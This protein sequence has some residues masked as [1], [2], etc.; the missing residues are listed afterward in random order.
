MLPGL[1]IAINAAS[2]SSA[3]VISVTYTL[4]DPDGL[5]LDA[6]GA[7]TP[8]IISLAYVAAYIPQGQQQYFAYTTEQATGAALGTITRPFFEL[9]GKATQVGPGQYQ[10]TFMAK[11]P[12]GFDPT[13]TTTVAVAGNRDLTPFDQGTNYG[14]ATFNFVPNGA[15]VTVTRDVIRTQSCN[16][17]HYQLAF[18][19]GYAA[20]MPMCVMCHQPQN[21]DPV[22]GNT[23]DFKVFAHKIHMGAQL[24]SVLGYTSG[25]QTIAPVPYEII[26]Y[27]NSVNNFST[28]V[29]PADPRRCE[30]CH[31][32]T[33]GAAQATAF[34][35]EPSR[36]ACGACHDNV[37]FATG[38][39]HP[40]GFQ[41]NDTECTNCHIPQGETPFD[42]SIQGAH[43]VPTD[44]TATYP[45][46]PDTL[47]AGINLAITSVTNTSAGQTPAVAFTLQDNSGN[48]IPLSQT[49]DLS[50]T[51]A[52]PTTDYGYT[53]FGSDTTSTPGYV[54]ESASK[55]ACSSSGACTYTFTHAIPAAATGTYTIGGEARMTVTVLAG[56]NAQQTIN[57]SP[58]NPVVNFSVDGSPVAP[59]RT[60]VAL[61][62][63]NAC[64]VDLMLHGGLRNNNEYCVLCHNPSNTDF[65]QRP[66]A[67]V[68]SERTQPFQGINFNL[69]IHRL[70]DGVNAATNPGGPPKY[71]YIVVGYMGSSNDFSGTLFPVMSPAGDATYMQDCAVC[72][73]NGSEQNLP[74]GLNAVQDPQSWIQGA[75]GNPVQPA[76]DACSGCHVSEGES[77][78][79]L[80]NTDVLGESCNVCHGVGAQFAV[81]AVH[82]Q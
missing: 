53:S 24:P 65:T 27:M 50:F 14:G 52:G 47:I 31:S 38:A 48:N 35:T 77:A 62:N 6:T 56:T 82:V 4:T 28:V 59:R 80:A 23:L 12:A 10:Y 41:L 1:N 9:G 55:A 3:G 49:S 39:N 72:H 13:V 70:H 18:H 37:D 61:A 30:V 17:C 60:V 5:P 75:T 8:G 25:T 78:H 58:A 11:A 34:L 16:T 51:M 43:V 57:E 26:G 79:F 33:T 76:S 42:A 63:C 69:L 22:T 7:T 29:D 46:N 15:P 71:P 36:A 40:G 66:N 81:D 64:H 2:I 44:T 21:A 68:V 74:I 32:Q 19:G 20:G 45:Q 73:T 67:V 54:T